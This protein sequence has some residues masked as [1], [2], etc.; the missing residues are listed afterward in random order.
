MQT[1][2]SVG[3]QVEYAPYAPTIHTPSGPVTV[4]LYAQKHNPFMYFSDINHPGSPRL[5]NIVPLG[6][7]F[8]HDLS[9]GN[10]PDLV[11]ISP[12]QCHDMHGVD[13]ASAALIHQP[14]CGYPTSGLD[15]G[16][17]QLGDAGLHRIVGQI[18]RSHTWKTTDSVI[19]VAWDEDDYS[20]ITGCC[21]SPTGRNGVVLGGGRAPAFVVRSWS[22]H[23]VTSNTAYNH[24]SLLATIENLWHLEC[25]ANA[26]SI[27]PARLMTPLFQ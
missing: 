26:C 21:A 19:V 6:G 15:H 16:A 11:W 25:L 10:V 2:P 24:Y 22:N 3:S 18:T 13:P 14:R 1:L 4:K 5:Q 20:S 8:Q 12:D 23:G 27:P 9:T 17:I 7:N